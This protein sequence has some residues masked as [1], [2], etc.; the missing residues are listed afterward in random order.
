MFTNTT[1]CTYLENHIPR[2]VELRAGAVAG[3][4]A[5]SLVGAVAAWSCAGCC[6]GLCDGLCGGS[7]FWRV[8]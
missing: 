5:G 6:D 7:D 1:G 3:A 8:L 2:T 4:V